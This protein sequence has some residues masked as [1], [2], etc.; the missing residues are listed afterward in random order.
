MFDKG[1]QRNIWSIKLSK[2]PGTKLSTPHPVW[3]MRLY[4][5]GWVAGSNIPAV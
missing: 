3:L 5:E 1:E 2:T 4:G